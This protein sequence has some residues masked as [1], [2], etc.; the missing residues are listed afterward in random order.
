MT[1]EFNVLITNKNDISLLNILNEKVCLSTADSHKF[2]SYADLV[3]ISPKVT[4]L[5][6]NIFIP[7]EG[8]VSKLMEERLSE[9]FH[10]QYLCSAKPRL[11]AFEYKFMQGTISNVFLANEDHSKNLINKFREFTV[12]NFY[13]PNAAHYSLFEKNYF[14][15]I[16]KLYFL[17][18]VK[19]LFSYK[20]Q[21]LVG[22]VTLYKYKAHPYFKTPAWHIGYWGYDRSMVNL[23]EARYIKNSWISFI[24]ETI[25]VDNCSIVGVIDS[26][27]SSVLNLVAKCG[28][29]IQAIRCDLKK[30]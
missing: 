23:D 11:A 22:C 28:F 12:T 26:F 8:T 7:A 16:S 19:S 3:N 24:N 30:F 21:K 29:T 9:K 27:N 1:K 15:E 6:D 13:E 18:E 20:N 4:K 25:V 2:S 14:L 5:I 17:G 10:I